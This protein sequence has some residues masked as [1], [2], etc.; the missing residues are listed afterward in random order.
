VTFR[1]VVF[2]FNANEDQ[3]VFDHVAGTILGNANWTLV[4]LGGAD[5]I[6]VDIDGGGMVNSS[7]PGGYSGYEM[8]IQVVGLTGTLED[9]DFQWLV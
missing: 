9:S 6:L 5:L 4:N 8:E 3:F 1:D 7:A 2:D